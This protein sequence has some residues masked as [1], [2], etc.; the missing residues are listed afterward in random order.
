MTVRH[1]FLCGWAT[2]LTSVAMGAEL[3]AMAETPAVPQASAIDPRVRVTKV[4]LPR[5]TDSD[6]SELATISFEVSRRPFHDPPKRWRPSPDVL[7]PLPDAVDPDTILS[8]VTI[9]PPE[10]AVAVTASGDKKWLS[11][12]SPKKGEILCLDVAFPGGDYK[13]Q[14][15]LT[16]GWTGCDMT[17]GIAARALVRNRTNVPWNGVEVTLSEW[18]IAL[19]DPPSVK[20]FAVPAMGKALSPA[21]DMSAQ[22]KSLRVIGIPSAA[23][24]G[25]EGKPVPV[26]MTLTMEE[27]K[28][29]GGVPGPVAV[30]IGPENDR[31]QVDLTEEQA[32]TLFGGKAVSLSFPSKLTVAFGSETA[33]KARLR[34]GRLS[35]STSPNYKVSNTN[36][37]GRL[38]QLGSNVSAIPACPSN[39]D[40]LQVGTR[41]AIVELLPSE[42]EMWGDVDG[43][44][45]EAY[46]KRIEKLQSL[47][48]SLED[49]ADPDLAKVRVANLATFLKTAVPAM[50]DDRTARIAELNSADQ[51]LFDVAFSE[52]STL[53]APDE[54]AIAILAAQARF[55]AAQQTAATQAFE[56]GIHKALE[57]HYGGP[58]FGSVPTESA[59]APALMAPDQNQDVL[60]PPRPPIEGT[61]GI[62]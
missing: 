39:A 26:T 34:E 16:V 19:G 1:A 53:E 17:P 45:L 47:L 13:I 32:K 5:R 35:V 37:N 3:P 11:V 29:L 52:E 50:I 14:Y 46:R 6:P 44:R 40:L 28:S 4:L 18:P 57:V 51:A 7:I 27:S 60:L 8:H 42:G 15:D 20:R 59:P 58:V 31:Q 21:K 2:V 23:L 43:T 49:S 61:K 38:I 22:A 10:T 36:R 41:T 48:T 30:R 12:P 25:P 62:D 55:L 24:P 9:D 56:E 54:Q 33:T